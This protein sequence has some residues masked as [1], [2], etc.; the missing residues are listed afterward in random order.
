MSK[1]Y[2]SS[3]LMAISSIIIFSLFAQEIAAKK[4][5]YFHN[6]KKR[7]GSDR[8]LFNQLIATGNVIVDFYADWCN[9]CKRMSPLIDH[10]AAAMPEFTFLKIDRDTALDLAKQLNITSIPTLIFYHDGKEIGR[11]TGGPLT[12]SKLEQL[13]LKT[14]S[15]FLQAQ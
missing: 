8:D 7:G 9:P 11:Y 14:Y 12:E 6:Q 4:P 1:K 3:L 15:N 10:A 13:I 5:L 2:V